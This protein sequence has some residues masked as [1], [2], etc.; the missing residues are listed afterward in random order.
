MA[1][2]ETLR[3]ISLNADS[4]LAVY[5][6]VPGALGSA[7]PN[8]GNQYLFVKVTGAHVVGKCTAAT[9]QPIGV[10]QNK[11][12]VSGQASTIAFAGV[13]LVR[14]A[15]A[16]TAG[17]IVGTDANGRA[18]AAGANPKVGITLAAAGVVDELV[19]VLLLN[20]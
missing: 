18:V 16:L 12:Q 13:S 17:T 2:E 7:N 4:S 5:T 14:A 9:D 3:T 8:S 10:L 1:Y 6:G 11:P 15:G 19:P 20:L